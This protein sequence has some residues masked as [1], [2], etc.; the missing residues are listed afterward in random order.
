MTTEQRTM[1]SALTGILVLSAAAAAQQP[2]DDGVF[3]PPEDEPHWPEPGVEFPLQGAFIHQFESNI[4][5]GGSFKVNRFYVQP[6]VD[7]LVDRRLSVSAGIGYS[8]DGYDFS[9]F[10]GLV[11]LDPWDDVHTLRLSGMVRWMPDDKWTVFA[12]PTIRFAAENGASFSDGLH[13]GGFV[14][15]SYKISDSLTLGPGFGALTQ[16]EDDVSVFPV[17]LLD[18]QITDDLA[19]RTGRGLGATQGPGLVLA[20]EFARHWEFVFGGRYES[21]RFRLNDTGPVPDGVGEES[22]F[23]LYGGFTWAPSRNVNLSIV[24]GVNFAGS[25]R[26][27]ASDGTTVAKQD[28]DPAGFFGAILTIRF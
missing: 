26:L 3:A 17:L 9:G 20:W 14:G 28:Y 4:D 22:S 23:P 7:W 18:W 19:L 2:P 25:L 27:D 11:G 5:G 15:F 21:Q 10:N 1:R 24:G 12:A 16:I 13:G 6:R 8:F